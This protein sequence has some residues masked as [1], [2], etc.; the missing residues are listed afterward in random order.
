MAYRQIG[1]SWD[2]RMREDIDLM[3]IEL[4]KEY[5]G[6]GLDATEAKEK[7]LQAVADALIAKEDAATA[8][9]MVQQIIDGE[10]D[11]GA[12]NT[13]IERKLNDLEAEY[14]PELSDLRNEIGDARGGY[15]SVD[16]RFISTDGKIEQVGDYV[17]DIS[18]SVNMFSGLKAAIEAESGSD[19]LFPS[20]TYTI[21]TPILALLK[22][23]RRWVASGKVVIKYTGEITGKMIDVDL[24]GFDFEV[25]GDFTF[26]ADKRAR[27]SLSI[28]NISATME[29]AVTLIM[30]NVKSINAYSNA[31]GYGSNGLFI[32]GGFNYIELNK[33]SAVDISRGAGV[34]IAGS[35]GTKGISITHS[36]VHAYPRQVVVNDPILENITSEELD[37]D[38]SNLD[39]DGL[40]VFAPASSENPD[41]ILDA[42]LIVRGGRFKDCR[43]RS[44]KSQMPSNIVDGPVFIRKDVKAIQNGCEVDFQRGWGILKDYVV[45]YSPMED[46]SS[47]LGSSFKIVSASSS[48]MDASL[49][50]KD[51]TI[52]N[53]L[54]TNLLIPYFVT[55]STGPF[56]EFANI[57]ISGNKVLGVGRISAGL[58]GQL[59]RAR[60]VSIENNYFNDLSTALIDS[61]DSNANTY[62][63][64]GNVNNGQSKAILSRAATGAA[65]KIT[66]TG[67]KGFDERLSNTVS[68]LTAPEILRTNIIKA[69]DANGGGAL[70][71]E[72]E[73]LADGASKK[74]SLRGDSAGVGLYMLSSSFNVNTQVV[75]AAAS[76]ATKPLTND[77]LTLVAF[78]STTDPN[79]AGKLNVW[80]S[81]DG[82]WVTN[83][84][85]SSRTITLASLA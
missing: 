8:K 84:L 82:I 65:A 42:M 83:R 73:V 18:V 40:S 59:N 64:N 19:L 36:G 14:A 1:S 31:E 53:N 3:F 43:G 69:K 26:D 81:A 76:N 39:C 70:A 38:A 2:S 78:G 45:H 20:G 12:L 71:L 85:G 33:C 68:G 11:T 50:V 41:I 74:F 27:E 66:G 37:G 54:P 63:V 16:E 23:K 60:N 52:F 58:R 77:E 32:Q 51:G 7:A 61:I 25:E 80:A 47:P 79:Q 6:A 28:R 10:V 57:N 35:Q 46:G 72:A 48:R 29:D 30:S 22:G 67:N 17:E 21:N 55:V 4:Y 5:T 49:D 34:G 75:F 56:N 44:I 62:K 9:E 13:E 24:N 15:P